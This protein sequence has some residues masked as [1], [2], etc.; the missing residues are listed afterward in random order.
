M[1]SRTLL[2]VCTLFYS[3]YLYRQEPAAAAGG[4]CRAG[5]R[6][7]STPPPLSPVPDRVTPL[8]YLY[9]QSLPPLPVECAEL[10]GDPGSTAPL[11][12]YQTV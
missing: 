2:F 11:L 12:L 6:P 7:G 9:R 3:W 1:Q 10:D 5:R 8:V 4:V